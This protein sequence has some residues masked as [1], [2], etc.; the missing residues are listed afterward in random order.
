MIVSWH[1]CKLYRLSV[2]CVH[3]PLS[4]N[5]QR[6]P[7][8]ATSLSLR[9]FH[10]AGEFVV[11][12][13]A[14]AVVAASACAFVHVF[15]LVVIMHGSSCL[16]GTSMATETVYVLPRLMH[17]AWHKQR[18]VVAAYHLGRLP[19]FP[20]AYTSV[21][22]WRGLAGLASSCSSAGLA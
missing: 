4:R 6:L 10:D 14:P 1:R 13:A 2:S 7:C 17:A 5:V 9:P 20:F 18:F 16:V 12:P 11:L 19:L 22:L 8:A 15:F 21:C 3:A